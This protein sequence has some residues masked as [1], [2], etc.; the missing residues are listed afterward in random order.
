MDN[1][2]TTN[3]L[4]VDV[5]DMIIELEEFAPGKFWTKR[6]V[7]HKRFP[8]RFDKVSKVKWNFDN[9]DE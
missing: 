5:G 9:E 3:P 6:I 8:T 7:S 1:N 2:E 4:I